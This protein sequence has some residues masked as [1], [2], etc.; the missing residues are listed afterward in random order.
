M[1]P[2]P[3][4]SQDVPAAEQTHS[5]RMVPGLLHPCELEILGPTAAVTKCPSCAEVVTT[6]THNTRGAAM[7]I[8]C[9]FCSVMGC[10]AGCCLIPFY[11]KR[12]RN[13]HHRCP[14]CQAH[15][16]THYPL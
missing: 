11:M 16:S 4:P 9:F 1:L 6:E 13:T 3:L 15:I 8:M 12:L 2:P 10:V 5:D 7:W 14:Q